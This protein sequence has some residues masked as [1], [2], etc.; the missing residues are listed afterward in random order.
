MHTANEV[1]PVDCRSGGLSGS[2]ADLLC[3]PFFEDD[4]ND[5]LRELDAATAGAIG[6]ARASGELTGKPHEL[7]LTDVVD[8][9][10]GTRRVLLVG[11]GARTR[12]GDGPGAGAC[13]RTGA[14]R[15]RP[16]GPPGRLRVRPRRRDP[17]DGPGGRRGAGAG[18]VP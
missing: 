9:A 1:L 7:Y 12:V 10:W 2:Q 16:Q 13:R 5:D 18:C 4:E 17:G 15:A 14:G 8:A 3:A 11:A 6:R